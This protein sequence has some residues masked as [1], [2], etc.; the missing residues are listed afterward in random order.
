M[1][2]DYLNLEASNVQ[3]VDDDVTSYHRMKGNAEL[4]HR[5][6]RERRVASGKA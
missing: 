3:S 5:G 6:N 1:P 4:L 2:V